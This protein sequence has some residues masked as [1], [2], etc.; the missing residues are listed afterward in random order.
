MQDLD[1]TQQSW[2]DRAARA[3]AEHKHHKDNGETV[4]MTAQSWML[5][6][7]ARLW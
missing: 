3:L 7:E 4:G 5:L 1:S 2:T 6:K